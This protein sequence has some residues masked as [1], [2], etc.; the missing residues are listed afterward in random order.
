MCPRCGLRLMPMTAKECFDGHARPEDSAPWT[1]WICPQDQEL[2]IP[3]DVN[4]LDVLEANKNHPLLMHSVRDVSGDE[5]GAIRIDPDLRINSL[6]AFP[7]SDQSD[8]GIPL[9]QVQ[10]PA[11]PNDVLVTIAAPILAGFSLATIVTIGTAAEVEP[12]ALPAMAC[13]AGSAV[14]LLFSIQMLAIGRLGGLRTA[15]WPRRVKAL[16]YE[17]GL[18]AF[19]V[20]LGLTLWLSTWPAAAV[21]GVVVVGL[22]VI[23]DLALV[24]TAWYRRNQWGRRQSSL[25]TR[26]AARAPSNWWRGR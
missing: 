23:C 19:L 16:L 25:G 7:P 2:V 11:D 24:A 20:G 9:E 10:D 3:D 21:A 18:L 8:W 26:R 15:R 17:L 4:A 14:L 5:T 12:G 6:V 22:A 13:F 1:V